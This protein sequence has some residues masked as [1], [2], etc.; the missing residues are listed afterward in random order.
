MTK[1]G[2]SLNIWDWYPHKDPDGT[3][4][5]GDSINGPLEVAFL[6]KAKTGGEPVITNRF[7]RAIDFAVMVT[8]HGP[9]ASREVP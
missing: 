5:C 8:D 3:L 6:G 2:I 4:N 1:Y 9:A 7:A